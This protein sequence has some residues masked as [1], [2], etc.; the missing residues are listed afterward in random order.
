MSSGSQGRE[1]F[2][3]RLP[4]RAPSRRATSV[5]IVQNQASS[6]LRNGSPRNTGEGGFTGARTWLLW[7]TLDKGVL[8][9][10]ARRGPQIET[11]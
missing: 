2:P 7:A 1:T 10:W 8:R 5:A 4:K 9:S 6:A 11:K 3:A